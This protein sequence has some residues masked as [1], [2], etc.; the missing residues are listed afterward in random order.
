MDDAFTQREH[1]RDITQLKHTDEQIAA[2]AT[3]IKRGDIY[4][5]AMA[6]AVADFALTA[7]STGKEEVQG[8]PVAGYA[9]TQSSEA[10]AVVNRFKELE[11]RV[12]REIDN[13]SGNRYGNDKFADQR[14]VATGRTY[15]QT[16]FMWLARSI[17]QPQRHALP[18]DEIA[19]G[20]VHQPPGV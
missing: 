12:L 20:A 8:L 11:E 9:R 18:G 19:N 16:G 1:E 10:I 15:L 7:M 2:W 17:F 6:Q 5:Y 14:C 3:T 13:I 4:N